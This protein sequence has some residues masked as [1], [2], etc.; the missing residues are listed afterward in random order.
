MARLLLISNLFPL[1]WEPTR[2]LF[3]LQQARELA[4]SHEVHVWVPVPWQIWFRRPRSETQ[5]YRVE[6]RIEVVPFP[7]FYIPGALRFTYALSMFFSLLVCHL[8][9]RQLR[10][11]RMLATWLYPDGVA[12]VGLAW[13]M[14]VPVVLKAHGTDVN[15]QCQYPARAFQVRWAARRARAVYCVSEELCRQLRKRNIGADRVV[16]IHNGVDLSRFRPQ[17]RDEVR[18]RIGVDAGDDVFLYVGNLKR[19]KGVMDLLEAFRLSRDRHRA[20]LFYIGEGPARGALEHAIRDAGLQGRVTL[21]GAIPHEKLADWMAAANAL[22]LPS[23]AE[24]VPNVV[25]EAMACGTPA[26]ATKVGGIPEVMPA[27]AGLL[28]PPGE[29]LRLADACSRILYE[30]WDRERIHRY[31]QRFS[32]TENASRLESLWQGEAAGGVENG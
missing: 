6:K 14:G 5:P 4:Q 22:V 2:G 25:L 1:P 20:R 19:E 24:G 11:E 32:W 9:H 18:S 28:V 12:A 15:T 10:P 29:P 31:A 27:C 8:R 17:P 3:N 16:A 7:Y 21:V 30:E 26:V 23:Y 13:L